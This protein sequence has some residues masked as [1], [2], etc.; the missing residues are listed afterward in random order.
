MWL[1]FMIGLWP[2]Q[3]DL[4]HI[5]YSEM[6]QESV[7]EYFNICIFV[8]EKKDEQFAIYPV[9]HVGEKQRESERLGEKGRY[10]AGFSKK[11]R[12]EN[13]TLV[14]SNTENR[15]KICRFRLSE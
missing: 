3:F 13:I 6:P 2:V 11:I 9:G 12:A 5:I 14:I 10:H 15:L 8:S 7:L 1:P 4:G